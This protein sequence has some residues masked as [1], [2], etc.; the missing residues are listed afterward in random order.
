M[1][2]KTINRTTASRLRTHSRR[3]KNKPQQRR[4]GRRG[5]AQ[6]SPKVIADSLF[7]LTLKPKGWAEIAS[8]NPDNTRES[9]KEKDLRNMYSDLVKAYNQGAKHW[10]VP[11]IVLDRKINPI[12][13][14]AVVLEAFKKNIC[15]EGF[16]VNIDQHS[17][18]GRSLGYHFTIYKEDQTFSECW[19]FFEI[20]HV[21]A[22]LKK[23]D[24]KLH[25]FFIVFL[26]SFIKKLNLPTYYNYGMDWGA[27]YLED[28]FYGAQLRLKTLSEQLKNL[29]KPIE[30]E[31]GADVDDDIMDDRD[32]ISINE[33]IQEVEDHITTVKATITDY[34]EGEAA[35]TAKLI[36]SV[37]VRS[38][39]SLLNTL[40]GFPAQNKLVGFMKQAC[41]LMKKK[42]TL[43]DFCYEYADDV[44]GDGLRFDMQVAVIWDW[45][46][47]FSKYQ[48]EGIDSMV[49]CAGVFYPT[50]HAQIVPDKFTLDKKAF[51]DS[52]TWPKSL[53]ELF[54]RFLKI[55]SKLTNYDN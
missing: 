36:K 51:M 54:T 11:T 26:A 5:P 23:N 18:K 42:A 24:K 21:L 28:H 46:D 49:Q 8:V 37:N 32:E 55:S 25:D 7:A 4:P 48:M 34:K 10:R 33:Q 9:E 22:K 12:K 40:K 27:M 2:A 31:I 6:N 43:A 15:P 1:P 39:Q 53:T 14:S 13:G 45:H 44:D 50:L 3:R 35:N 16:N 52:I 17:R 30:I 20:K 29:S 19:H 41:E 38:P 47:H